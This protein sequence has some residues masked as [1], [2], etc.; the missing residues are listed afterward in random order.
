MKPRHACLLLL[1]CFAGLAAPA[2]AI[3]WTPGNTA[4]SATSSDTKLF[5]NGLQIDCTAVDFTGM[6]GTR[7]PSL[8]ARVNFGAR[9]P[10]CTI[11]GPRSPVTITCNGD[12]LTLTITRYIDPDEGDGTTR[13]PPTFQCSIGFTVSGLYSCAYTLRGPQNALSGFRYAS[14][15]FTFSGIADA[16]AVGHVQSDHARKTAALTVKG[17][18]PLQPLPH[19]PIPPV[20]D[21]LA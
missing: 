4:V 19:V 16:V 14:N 2:H 1:S 21:Q 13:S 11:H 6:T 17:R 3:D 18:R 7:S 15:V 5:V 8:S 20:A 12:S 10:S 9:S